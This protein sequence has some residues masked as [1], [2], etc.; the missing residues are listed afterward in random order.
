MLG[1]IFLA[2]PAAEGN[3]L[4]NLSQKHIYVPQEHDNYVDYVAECIINCN[5]DTSRDTDQNNVVGNYEFTLTPRAI[6]V[7]NVSM[8]MCID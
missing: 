6:F 8:L 2:S 5:G 3:Q 7:P 1:S 4:Y